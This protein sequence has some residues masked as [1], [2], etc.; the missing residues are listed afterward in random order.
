MITKPKG[1]YDLYGR[2]G[3]E[4]VALRNFIEELM[5]KFNY[6]YIKNSFRLCVDKYWLVFCNNLCI[7]I[8]YWVYF[9]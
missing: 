9:L 5:D 6:E 7:F 8:L 3:K 2:K 4:T 1:T